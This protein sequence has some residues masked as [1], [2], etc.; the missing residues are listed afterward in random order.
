M[1]I[2]D[3]FNVSTA[4]SIVVAGAGVKVAKVISKYLSYSMEIEH[5][6]PLVVQ[7]MFWK[8][9]IVSWRK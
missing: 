8:L 4:S 9:W 6:R 1:T 7:Q 3:T 5:L 2:K